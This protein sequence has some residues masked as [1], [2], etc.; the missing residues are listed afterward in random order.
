MERCGGIPFSCAIVTVL[1]SDTRLIGV[2]GGRG[3][4]ELCPH[5]LLLRHND[6]FTVRYLAYWCL[7]GG[8]GVSSAPIPF[9]CAIT[10]VGRSMGL[11]DRHLPGFMAWGGGVRGG[12]GG[13]LIP[14]LL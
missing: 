12:V 5:T 6:C 7:E 3:R 10:T 14:H 1:G 9:S 4:V 8:G 11:G 13:V 2:F